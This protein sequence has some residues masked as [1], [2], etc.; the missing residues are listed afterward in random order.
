MFPLPISIAIAASSV[1]AIKVVEAKEVKPA[2][3]PTVAPRPTAVLPIVKD[4]L[5]NEEFGILARLNAP[6]A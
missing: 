4:E 2:K 5:A 3:V 1:P 6:D